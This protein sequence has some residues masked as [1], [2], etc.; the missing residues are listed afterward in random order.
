MCVCVWGLRSGSAIDATPIGGGVVK[1][2]SIPIGIEPLQFV[3]KVKTSEVVSSVS[4]LM[5]QYG[6]RKV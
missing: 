1:C 2:C 6:G 5:K 3:N 4:R